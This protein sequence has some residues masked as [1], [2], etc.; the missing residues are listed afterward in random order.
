[1]AMRPTLVRPQ[2]VMPAVRPDGVQPRGDDEG[3]KGVAR[4]R[5]VG[6]HQD[7]SGHMCSAPALLPS[8]RI[9]QRTKVNGVNSREYT[10]LR[11][12]S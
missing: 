8:T 11:R 5:V 2:P 7:T 6:T 12:H 9:I 10:S 4:G 1:M 3:L